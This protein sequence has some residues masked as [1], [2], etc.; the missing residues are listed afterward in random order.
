MAAASRFGDTSAG[1]ACFPPTS[2]TGGCIGSVLINGLAAAVVGSI[3]AAHT[4]GTTTHAGGARAISSGS[5]SVFIG[6]KPAARIGDPIACGDVV[7]SGSGNV[8]TGG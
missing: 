5:G 1:H 2:I 6:G 7:G 4:C 3:F 8:F